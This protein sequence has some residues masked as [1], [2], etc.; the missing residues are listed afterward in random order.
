M[1]KY[2]LGIDIGT[3]GT[4]TILVDDEGRVAAAK[5]VEYPLETPKPGWTQQ[6]PADW[7]QAAAESIRAVLE[8][9]KVPGDQIAG[10]GFSGQMHG[11]VALDEAGEVVRPAILWNDQRTERQCEEIT[12]TAGGLPGL[13]SY[14]NNR[15]LT[16]FT[17]GKILWMKEEEPE[18]FART[19]VILNPK[20]YVRYKLTGVVATEVSDASGTGLF[21]V[22]NRCFSDELIAKLGL[23]RSLFPKCYESYEIVGQVTSEAAALTGLPAGLP[24]T[25]GGGDAVIQTM[26]SGL[27]HQGVLGVVIGTS[28]VVAMGLDGYKEN[29]NGELQLFCSN[30]KH[31]WHAIGVTLAAGGSY[32]W[33]RDALCAAEKEE[34]ARTGKDVY[35]ILGE[36]AEKVAPGCGG[37][38]FLPYLSGERCPH[39]DSDARG[40]FYGLGL[41]HGKGA[42]SRAVMEGVTFSLRDVWEKIRAMDETI[43]PEKVVLSGGGA[44]SPLWRQIVADVFHMP[45]VTVSGSGEG[46]A[47]GAALVAGVGLGIWKDLI[48]ATSVLREE[49]RTEPI[50][51]NVEVYD[52]VY[53]LYDKIYLALKDSFKDLSQLR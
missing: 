38:L 41:E 4:K 17:G 36:A 35:D 21:D 15:M 5:T 7:W 50:P 6:N 48:E 53:A 51:E 19:K 33:Y 25:A 32:R 40:V 42:M 9:S 29:A 43:R 30:A 39:F 10:V 20:D 14:T 45:V 44:L 1:K 18:N 52:R 47:Y 27:V 46:G 2:I 12:E 8:K 34:A 13:L 28:G 3:S 23:A 37:L 16:G 31:L 22:K 11:M 26:G 24:V 49:T